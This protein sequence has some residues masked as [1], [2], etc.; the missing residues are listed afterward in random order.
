MDAKIK[1]QFKEIHNLDVDTLEGKVV[2]FLCHK[3]SNGEK[4]RFIGK[5]KADYLYLAVEYP[6]DPDDNVC[7]CA[8]TGVSPNVTDPRAYYILEDCWFATDGEFTKWFACKDNFNADYEKYKEEEKY[9]NRALHA[10]R[11]VLDGIIDSKF[12]MSVDWENIFLGAYND[13]GK[14]GNKG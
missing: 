6:Y 4:V 13:Y 14:T 3:C 9:R 1:Q 2:G 12:D 5:V 11:T 10:C 8:E 7:N